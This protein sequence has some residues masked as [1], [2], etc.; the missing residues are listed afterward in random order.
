M[1]FATSKRG[2]RK[3]IFDGYVYSIDRIRDDKVYW[4][5]EERKICSGRTTVG[6]VICNGPSQHTHAG[7]PSSVAA[8]K[9]ITAIKERAVNSEEATST[10]VQNCTQ[11]FSLAAAGSLPNKEALARMVRRKRKA[12]DG[13]DVP[14]ELSRT[15]RGDDFLALHDEDLDLYIFTTDGNLDLLER[16]THWFC[17]GTFDS[18]PNNYQLYTIHALIVGSRTVPLVYCIFRNKDRDT[19][20]RI[21]DYLKNR[22]ANLAP[23][24]VLLDFEVAEPHFRRGHSRMFVSIWT[25]SLA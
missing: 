21:F 17:D 8:L 19:Y 23:I 25:V 6:H 24:S 12:P 13:D 10:L 14:Q 4:K 9:T 15:T 3:L 16:N 22:R 1:E 11:N 18:A 20:R 5:C 2:G 7:D